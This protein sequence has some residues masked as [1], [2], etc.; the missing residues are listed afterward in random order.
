MR[1][2]NGI[3]M[4]SMRLLCKMCGRIWLSH[5]KKIVRSYFVFVLAGTLV[6]SDLIK[7][8][9][10]YLQ[11]SRSYII[12]HNWLNMWEQGTQ[13]LMVVKVK[14]VDLQDILFVSSVRILFMEIISFT[15]IC[16]L[17]ILLA[18]YAQGNPCI[19]PLKRLSCF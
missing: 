2:R 13:W 16:L 8:W 9:T 10:R 18:T 17:S 4:S 12:E 6:F 3:E 19:F 5:V 15:C 1:S 14:E 7:F 11:V